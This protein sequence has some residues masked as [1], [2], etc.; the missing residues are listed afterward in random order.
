MAAGAGSDEDQL[1]SEGSDL[2]PQHH[3][4]PQ[5]DDTPMEPPAA[6]QLDAQLA[7]A[8]VETASDASEKSE[9]S[10]QAEAV[11]PIAVDAANK[12]SDEENEGFDTGP[13]GSSG[14]AVQQAHSDEAPLYPGN[15]Y[16][17]RS[18]RMLRANSALNCFVSYVRV[19]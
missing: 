2:S 17:I 8:D 12:G 3:P 14:A 11:Q 15:T 13:A 9:V 4:N 10:T 1:A 7:T 6:Q 16:I 19:S 18:C 5:L